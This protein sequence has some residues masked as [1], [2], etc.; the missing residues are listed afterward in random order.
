MPVTFAHAISSTRPTTAITAADPVDSAPLAC[1]TRKRTSLVANADIR[2]LRFVCGYAAASCVPMSAT[3]AWACA[4]VTPGFSR[5]LTKNDR[6]PRRSMRVR[7]VGDGMLSLMPA[8]STSSTCAIGS[9]SSGT[10]SGMTPVKRAGATPTIVYGCPRSC[11]GAADD[12][13]I[14]AEVAPPHAMRDAP[15]PARHQAHR[16]P[17]AASARAAAERR[18]CRSDSR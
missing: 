15:P 7:P 10:I 18:A 12:A 9:Q 14:A 13:R 2:R 17:A 8:G 4:A 5:P 3:L 11:S 6:L 16:R 1:G